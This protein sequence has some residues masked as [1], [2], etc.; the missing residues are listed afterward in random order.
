M[1]APRFLYGEAQV[2]VRAFGHISRA[3]QDLAHPG[4]HWFT[5][6]RDA[7]GLRLEQAKHQSNRR[8]LAGAVG[9][10]E[11]VDRARGDPEIEMIEQERFPGPVGEVLC[12][13]G[14]RH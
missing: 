11:P 13:D 7:S 10:Q 5:Q 9:S 14:V 2:Q 6:D 8:G 3:C 12:L 1:K 4:G